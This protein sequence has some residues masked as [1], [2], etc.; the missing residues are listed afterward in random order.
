MLLAENGFDKE[1][2]AELIADRQYRG[3]RNLFQ[4]DQLTVFRLNSLIMAI[5]IIAIISAMKAMPINTACII[6]SFIAI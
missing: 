3:N 4:N 2:A 5:T 1:E 6:F